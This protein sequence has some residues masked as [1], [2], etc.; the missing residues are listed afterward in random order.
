MAIK[1]SATSH[2]QQLLIVEPV[3]SEEMDMG[4]L[5]DGLTDEDR[6]FLCDM[7]TRKEVRETVF[8]IEPESVAGPDGFGAFFYQTCWDFMS[9]DVFGAV[10]E[11]FR[12]GA[13][14]KSFTATTIS[15]IP[16]TDCPASWNS[17]RVD[18]NVV[19]KLDIAKAYDRVSWEFLYLV[20]QRKGF[21]QRWINLVANAVSNCWFSVLVNGGMQGSFIQPE[22]YGRAPGRVRVSHLA[23]ADDMEIFTNICSQN[24]E[25]LRYFLRAY[26]RV[27]GQLINN[28]KSSFIIGR[29]VSTL[30]TQTVQTIMGYQLKHLPVTY[31]GVPLYKGNRK[32]CYF[33][34]IIAWIRS[35]LQ[36]W[37]MTNLSQGGRL[38]LIKSVLEATPLHLLQVMSPP[39]SVLLAIERIFNEFFWGSYN[40]RKHIHWT[41]WAKICFSMAE[42]GLGVQG[43]ADYV[44]AFSM[45]LCGVFDLDLRYGRI[46]YMAGIVGLCTRL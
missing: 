11:F 21:P 17:R 45:K 35:M 18:A 13:L 19:F 7:P 4:N 5:E 37:A 32:A 9:E 41:S 24:M 40:G 28:A 29:H 38:A 30:Q 22:A 36:G 3:F 39:K 33:D 6:R 42:G 44:R 20:L 31:L 25:L 10:T 12:G 1:R 27:S 34:P 14:P 16:K 2:F 23:Y 46:S 43:L 26:Q 8:S 15:L